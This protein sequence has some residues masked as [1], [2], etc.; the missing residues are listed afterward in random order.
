MHLERNFLLEDWP[1]HAVNLVTLFELLKINYKRCCG[2]LFI[3]V[4]NLKRILTF[5]ERCHDVD[6]D[7]T[8]INKKS[9]KWENCLFNVGSETLNENISLYE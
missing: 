9:V 2:S 3:C 6:G 4:T 1:K 7:N 5:Q 8:K